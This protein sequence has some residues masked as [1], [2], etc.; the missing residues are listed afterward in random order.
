MATNS[1]ATQ[2]SI[3]DAW[4]SGPGLE[5]IAAIGGL[6]PQV[7]AAAVA[8]LASRYCITLRFPYPKNAFFITASPYGPY[9]R[10][11]GNC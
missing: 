5:I 1:D 4:G 11:T 8:Y 10:G 6:I 7:Q 9:N 3:F 2:Y